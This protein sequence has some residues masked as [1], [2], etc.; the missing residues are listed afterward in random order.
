MGH[1]CSSPPTS[2]SQLKLSVRFLF[3][4]DVRDAKGDGNRRGTDCV[5]PPADEVASR[6]PC[7]AE[8]PV[9]HN[10]RTPQ[11]ATSTCKLR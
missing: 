8:T 11:P 3:E 1:A 5:S 10:V 7:W 2:S 6:L 4:D 9:L